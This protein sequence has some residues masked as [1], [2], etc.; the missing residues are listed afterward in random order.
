M[1]DV[2]YCFDPVINDESPSLPLFLY[3]KCGRPYFVHTLKTKVWTAPSLL[4]QQLHRFVHTVHTFSAPILYI[5]IIINIFFLFFISKRKKYRQYGQ[6]AFIP[7]VSRGLPVH[8]FVKKVWTKCGRLTK[9]WTLHLLHIY[10]RN[11]FFPS[12]FFLF[13]HTPQTSVAA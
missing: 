9:V 3:K 5:Y 6:H 8:T 11:A 4:P 1:I 2:N 13:F 10:R 12:F 7:F